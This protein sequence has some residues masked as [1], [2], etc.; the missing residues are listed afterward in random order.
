MRD[1]SSY[2]YYDRVFESEIN[3]A[4]LLTDSNYEEMLYK[5]AMR[6]GFYD[7]Q[8]PTPLTCSASQWFPWQQA[9]RDKYRDMTAV[10][11]G[12]NW[13]LVQWFVEVLFHLHAC[14]LQH[15]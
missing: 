14:A 2:T 8:V 5:E 6:T 12:M 11:E 3:Q 9:A 13:H 15:D 10:G 1:S 7:L 4:V